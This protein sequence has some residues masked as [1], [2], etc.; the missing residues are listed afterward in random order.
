M[1]YEFDTVCKF[2]DLTVFGEIHK[3]KKLFFFQLG[4]FKVNKN[5]LPELY[6]IKCYKSVMAFRSP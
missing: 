6:N 4:A 1:I 5:I 3:N 2:H